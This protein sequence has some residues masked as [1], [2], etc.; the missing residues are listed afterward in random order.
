MDNLLGILR[1]RV[2]RGV[3]LAV[4][5]VSSSD[6]YV[7]LKLGRQVLSL[8]LSLPLPISTNF[9]DF[10]IDSEFIFLLQKL[11]TK[12]VKQ[13]VNPQW[14]E[15]LSFTVTDPNLPLTL[16]NSKSNHYFLNRGP[17]YKLT[18]RICL[19]QNRLCTITTSSAKTTKWETQRSI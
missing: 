19:N 9:N 8:S 11:K 6:P 16:V 7:V 12:V 17:V 3:N 10:F 18:H 5:D 2:Q 13:N 4:R 14:Q 1:V 15:D